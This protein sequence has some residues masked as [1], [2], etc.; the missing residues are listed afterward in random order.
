VSSNP[1]SIDHNTLPSDRAVD[2]ALVDLADGE[3]AALDQVRQLEADNRWLRD[4]LHEA[5]AML[6]RVNLQLDRAKRVT[7]A[8]H[9]TVRDLRQGRAV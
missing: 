6:R 8:L 2:L 4:T 1:P 5:V 7:L 9:Q 3:A